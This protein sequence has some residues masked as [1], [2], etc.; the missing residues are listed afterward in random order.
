[1][2]TLNARRCH[3][4]QLAVTQWCA[5]DGWPHRAF[6]LPPIDAARGEIIFV[7]GRG[8]FFE[9][10][11]EALEHWS[12]NRW[13]VR[14]FDWRGQGGSG[15]THPDA[16]CH[17]AD[18]AQLVGDFAGFC[19]R[20]D[21]GEG[22]RVVIGHSMGAHVLLRALAEQRVQCDGA[23]LLSPMLG[24]R[25]GR[26]GARFVN[27]LGNIGFLPRLAQRPIW[28]GPPGINPGHL[29]ACPDRHADKLWWK[30]TQPHLARGG[31]TWLW[32]AAATRSMR[33][34]EHMLRARVPLPPCLTI[35]GARDRVIDNIATRRVLGHNPDIILRDIM[36]G[37][38]ELLRE[39][40]EARLQ[41]L[42]EIDGFLQIVGRMRQSQG[43]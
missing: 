16:Y 17:I 3:P 9:K 37:G 34:L 19:A 27:A 22:P 15:V 4:D 35:S 18:F 40:D 6:S 5:K 25:A 21:S 28:R 24:I 38:H 31:P 13:H 10:Y 2:T 43:R 29:T 12:A 23:V 39:S 42:N 20:E 33:Q 36:T 41:T 14:G 11:I 1:M 26:M 30:E 32:L 8:D 7:G